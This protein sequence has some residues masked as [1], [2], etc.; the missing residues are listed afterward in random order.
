MFLDLPQVYGAMFSS[1]SASLV[2]LHA[3][4]GLVLRIRAQKLDATWLVI[5]GYSPSMVRIDFDPS[6]Y[7]GIL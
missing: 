4:E 5:P 1:N 7:S 3:Q 6:P 2:A